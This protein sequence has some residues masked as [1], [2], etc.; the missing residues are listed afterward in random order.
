VEKDRDEFAAM[1]NWLAQEV[2]GMKDRHRKVGSI[3]NVPN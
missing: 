1:H 3:L 2:D